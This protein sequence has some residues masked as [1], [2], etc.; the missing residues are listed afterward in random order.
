[1]SSPRLVA[2]IAGLALG[3][4]LIVVIAL[5]T[6]WAPLGAK[7]STPVRWQRDF[8]PSEHLREQAFHHAVRPPAYLSLAAGLVV[9]ALLGLTSWGGRL[10]ERVA[11]PLGG[12]WGWQ[13]LA[14]ALAVV[15][16]QALISLPFDLRAEQVLRDY[17][18]ST[19]SWAS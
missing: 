9:V 10:A 2:L 13:V 12:G 11:R 19:Q 3:A 17:G 5:T 16:L 6:P 14:A 18:L 8:S 4:A 7:V 15:L 1:M